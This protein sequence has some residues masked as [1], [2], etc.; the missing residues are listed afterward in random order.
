MLTPSL[1]AAITEKQELEAKLSQALKK[2]EDLENQLKSRNTTVNL[3]SNSVSTAINN[4]VVGVVA[5]PPPPPPPPPVIKPLTTPL[6]TPIKTG[7]PPPPPPP[8]PS[9]SSSS[10][11]PTTRS[12]CPRPPPPPPTP[13]APP[14]PPTPGPA[15]KS[16]LV[17]VFHKLGMKRKTKWNISGQIKRTNWKVIP[18][19][20]LTEKA[21]WTQVDEEKYA[22]ANLISEL[23][24]RFGSKPSLLKQD[25]SYDPGSAKKCKELRF[26]D[27]KAAQNLSVVLGINL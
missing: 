19:T 18:V 16:Q 3:T 7:N 12:T 26:L 6:S 9:L 17:D 8:P 15:A 23:Q 20:Q 27:G 4:S 11:A 1:E 21:F 5:P 25:S 2:V 10:S 24:S 14:P 22:S 13:G